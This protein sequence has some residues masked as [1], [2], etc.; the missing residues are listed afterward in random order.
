[1]THHVPLLPAESKDFVEWEK[2]GPVIEP[3]PGEGDF[4]SGGVGLTSVGWIDEEVWMPTFGIEKLAQVSRCTP[5]LPLG[6][7]FSFLDFM[8]ILTCRKHL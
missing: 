2:K 5:Q 1:M 4:D 7:P 3:G 6:F 8:P